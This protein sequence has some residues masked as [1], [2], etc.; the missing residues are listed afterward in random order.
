MPIDRQIEVWQSVHS[1]SAG[2][3]NM[4]TGD[5]DYDHETRSCASASLSHSQR[6]DIAEPRS[7]WDHCCPKSVKKT[8][9]IRWWSCL[10]V[11]PNAI[12]ILVLSEWVHACMHMHAWCMQSVIHGREVRNLYYYDCQYSVLIDLSAQQLTIYAFP[13]I[14]INSL[15]LV[16]WFSKDTISCVKEVC[17]NSVN[18]ATRLKTATCA[19]VEAVV[20]A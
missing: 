6:R 18:V 4:I 16:I 3:E 7:T 12:W 14:L 2:W 11:M 19:L 13:A 15:V 17:I 5:S 20:G 9:T 10:K 8:V 1:T